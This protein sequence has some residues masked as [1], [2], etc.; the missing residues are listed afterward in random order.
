MNHN[1]KNPKKQQ[2]YV[3]WL[4]VRVFV[5]QLL[6]LTINKYLYHYKYAIVCVCVSVHDVIC[7]KSIAFSVFWVSSWSL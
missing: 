5:V 3:G 4:H 2:Q 1:K 6:S 7:G